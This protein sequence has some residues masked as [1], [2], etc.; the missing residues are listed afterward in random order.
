MGTGVAAP[1][2][3]PRP[4]RWSS[5][6]GH[7]PAALGPWPSLAADT[8]VPAGLE[9]SERR[10]RLTSGVL[11]LL[12]VAAGALCGCVVSCCGTAPWGAGPSGPRCYKQVWGACVGCVCLAPTGSQGLRSLA[13]GPGST[14]PPAAE[15][16]GRTLVREEGGAEREAG[17]QEQG[18]GAQWQQQASSSGWGRHLFPF[19]SC[20]ETQGFGGRV[21]LSRPQLWLSLPPGTQ[22]AGSGRVNWVCARPPGPAQ[23]QQTGLGLA[24]GSY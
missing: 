6:G 14:Q 16:P 13:P 17:G 23:D 2:P 24:E 21:A 7:C 5:S 4:L 22:K 18:A 20:P 3:G 11:G 12:Q 10:L 1:E 8:G 15:L 9:L 19:G